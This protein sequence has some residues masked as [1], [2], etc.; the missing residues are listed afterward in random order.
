MPRSYTDDELKEFLSRYDDKYSYKT[1]SRMT[2]R[3]VH[4]VMDIHDEMFDRMSYYNENDYDLTKMV[5]E[6]QETG[7]RY[8]NYEK[9]AKVLKLTKPM[10][11]KGVM[12]GFTLGNQHY[13]FIEE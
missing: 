12:F 4:D 5:V 8:E 11:F 9:L 6:C 2:C 10:V 1:I 7:E 13:E 3:D